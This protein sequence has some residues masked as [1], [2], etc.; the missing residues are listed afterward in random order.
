[1]N[2]GAPRPFQLIMTADNPGEKLPPT[3]ISPGIARGDAAGNS[4][5]GK[6]RASPAIPDHELIRCIGSGSYGE[7]WLARNVMG[8][9]RAVKIVYRKTFENDRPFEREFNGIQ[10]F[11]PISR[12]DNSQVDILH[13][14][15]NQDYF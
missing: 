12:S 3:V 9:Y 1:M 7:V 11:E 10:K 2:S 5:E 4:P 14:G 6:P 13:V 15:R 8:N